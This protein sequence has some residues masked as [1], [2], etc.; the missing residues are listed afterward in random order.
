MLYTRVYLVGAVL[1][2][3]GIALIALTGQLPSGDYF[4]I[5]P[6]CIAIGAILF[7]RGCVTK[8]AKRQQLREQV[9]V[10]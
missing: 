6:F 1:S 5:G 2:L 9:S 7:I 8:M 10:D 3:T 4:L